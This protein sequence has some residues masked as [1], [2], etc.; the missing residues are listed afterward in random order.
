MGAAEE[1]WAMGVLFQAASCPIDLI[2]GS[3]RI[4]PHAYSQLSDA[5]A[6]GQL[7]ITVRPGGVGPA[8]ARVSYNHT[9][10]ILVP[11]AE[12][13]GLDA[14]ALLVHEAT[15]AW[16][17]YDPI[18]SMAGCW[19]QSDFEGIAYVAQGLYALGVSGGADITAVSTTHESALV[20]ARRI[21]AGYGSPFP[22]TPVDRANIARATDAERQNILDHLVAATH[23]G[24]RPYARAATR[25]VYADGRPDDRDFLAAI[26]ASHH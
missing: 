9:V 11:S 23:E 3:C 8:E 1:D 25:I 20:C 10:E 26:E 14:N 5:I 19:P 12:H 24:S 13:G 7:R 22:Y 18:A 21:F 16:F 17:F 2:Y 4:R 15:H 6:S